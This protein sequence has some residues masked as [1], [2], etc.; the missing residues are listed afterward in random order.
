MP[1]LE[2]VSLHF[3]YEPTS[4]QVTEDTS[5]QFCY[6]NLFGDVHLRE[7]LDALLLKLQTSQNDSLISPTGTGLHRVDLRLACAV[8]DGAAVIRNGKVRFIVED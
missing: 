7:V 4:P 2:H 3:L 6:L 5:L 1:K 8:S